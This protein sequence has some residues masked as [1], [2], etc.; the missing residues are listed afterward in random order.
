MPIVFIWWQTL[1]L[2]VYIGFLYNGAPIFHT[3]FSWWVRAASSC[4][5]TISLSAVICTLSL[6]ASS[7]SSMRSAFC[8]KDS[9]YLRSTVHKAQNLL[10]NPKWVHYCLH[11]VWDQA[12]LDLVIEID[13][14]FLLLT[15]C[16]LSLALRPLPDGSLCFPGGFLPCSFICLDMDGAEWAWE[17]DVASR[18]SVS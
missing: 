12:V 8:R 18:V 10:L 17:I 1:I 11:H 9:W 4:A 13:G 7:S 3:C 2:K 16:G 15:C 6:S 5:N 14:C